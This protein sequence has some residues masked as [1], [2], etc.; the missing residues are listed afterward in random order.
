MIFFVYIRVEVRTFFAWAFALLMLISSG[1][2]QLAMHSCPGSGVFVFSDCGMHGS[3]EKHELPDCCKK[4]LPAQPQKE[5][6]G[7]CEEFFVFS[8]TPKFGSVVCTETAAPPAIIPEKTPT[9]R[10]VSDLYSSELWQSEKEIPPKLLYY[11]A[12]H[13]T[14]LI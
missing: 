10:V 5:D 2:L 14:W 11:Q 7:N 8:I 12:L 13:C 9:I 6:C 3:T 4:K 1:C